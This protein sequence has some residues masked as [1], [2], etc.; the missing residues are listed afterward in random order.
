[1]SL[2][3]IVAEAI[4]ANESAGVI[5]RH[6]AINLAVPKVLADEEMTEMCVRSHLSKVMASTCKKRA[7]E[8]A[9]T[10]AAQSSLFGLHDAHV[11]DHGEGIIK[12]T[13]ALTRDEF[14]G[15][16]RVRQEQ[17]TADMAYLKR[18][19]DAELETRAIWDRNP[20]WT[21][22]QVEAAYARKDAKAA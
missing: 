22:G 19:R 1:M 4:D 16:I 11:L 8:L 14:R 9:A 10:S 13:E 3:K 15:I 6:N 2:N 12:R 18:L 21:W 5:N 20:N 17:V 7:R